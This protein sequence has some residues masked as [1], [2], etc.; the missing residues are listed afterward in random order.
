MATQTQPVIAAHVAQLALSKKANDA[1]AATQELCDRTEGKPHLSVGI[2]REETANVSIY[3]LFNQYAQRD[4]PAVTD[5][6]GA[7]SAD[8][9]QLASGS[10]GNDGAGTDSGSS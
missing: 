2:G 8:S 7:D 6:N 4:S 5:N 10:T 1:L 3:E 9:G